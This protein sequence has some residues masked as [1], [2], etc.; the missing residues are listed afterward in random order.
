[1]EQSGLR[2]DT[3]LRTRTG[4]RVNSSSSAHTCTGG[5]DV[6]AD[7]DVHSPTPGSYTRVLT[8]ERVHVRSHTHAVNRCRTRA[9]LVAGPVDAPLLRPQTPGASSTTA[10]SP[11]WAGTNPRP[12]SLRDRWLHLG[13]QQPRHRP[14]NCCPDPRARSAATSQEDEASSTPLVS[15]HFT[16]SREKH[17]PVYS[18]LRIPK[19]VRAPLLRS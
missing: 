12:Q 15:H 3:C 5:G 9:G 8:L 2:R 13:P 18:D 1:M 17:I 6:Q 7:T 11:T 10:Q 16:D 19:E 14:V 4:A